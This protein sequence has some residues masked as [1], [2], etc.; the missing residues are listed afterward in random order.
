MRDEH[1]FNTLKLEPLQKEHA[2]RLFEVLKDPKIYTYIPEEPPKSEKSL[3]DKFDF[4]SHG[5]PEHLSELWFNY[6]LFDNE[7]SKYIGTIQATIFQNS[8]KASIAYLLNPIYW[9]KGYATQALRLMI[10]KLIE[11]HG[12]VKF[13]ACIDARNTKSIELVKRLGFKYTAFE[14]N[15]DFF[16]GESSDEYTYTASSDSFSQGNP[17]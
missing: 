8:N 1:V 17:N 10:S 16:K 14:K 9:G 5:A 4:L 13:E 7:I 15:A 2:S 3:I 12:V 11:E 6:A